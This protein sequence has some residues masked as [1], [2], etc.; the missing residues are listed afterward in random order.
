MT[1]RP[2]DP[3][4]FW[5]SFGRGPLARGFQRRCGFDPDQAGP[6]FASFAS[7]IDRARS[8]GHEWPDQFRAMLAAAV[9]AV[10][11]EIVG[12]VLA[13]ER[14]AVREQAEAVVNA[15][16]DERLEPVRKAYRELLARVERL[17][18]AVRRPAPVQR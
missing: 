2:P 16:V 9:T 5:D 17:E 4:P 3:E 7:A 1:D 10:L 18:R 14:Q 15:L 11:P 6:G 12:P 13:A 8:N